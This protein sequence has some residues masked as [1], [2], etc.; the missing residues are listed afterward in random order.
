MQLREAIASLITLI[1][2]FNFSIARVVKHTLDDFSNIL[3]AIKNPF[4]FPFSQ[5]WN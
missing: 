4:P 5:V 2:S 1:I 3:L